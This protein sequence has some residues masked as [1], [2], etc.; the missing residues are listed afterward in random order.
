[1]GKVKWDKDSV[2]NLAKSCKTKKEF[3]KHSGAY[4]AA[5]N[6]GWLEE[7][8]SF[9]TPTT[10][11]IIDNLDYE[12]CKEEALKYKSRTEFKNNSSGTY[13]KARKLKILDTICSHMYRKI[14]PKGYW[15]YEK[16]KEEALKYTS[17]FEFQKK[18]SSAYSKSYEEKW[19]DE[20]CSHMKRLNNLKKRVIY[21]FE[22][23]LDKN[24]NRFVYVGLTYNP[25]TRNKDHLL[26]GPVFDHVQKGNINFKYK[27]LTDFISEEEAQQK[28]FQILENYRNTGWITLNKGK[29]GGLGASEKYTFETCKKLSQGLSKKEFTINENKAYK[30]CSRKG[31]LKLLFTDDVKKYSKEECEEYIKNNFIKT[32]NEL[33]KKHVKIY[34]IMYKNKWLDELLPNTLRHKFIYLNKELCKIESKKYKNKTEFKSYCTSVYNFSKINGWLDEF[35]PKP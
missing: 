34:T 28:E 12:K 8:Y 26:R 4:D 31:W 33:Q 2:I 9:L 21:S 6:K 24:N 32:R 30:T 15:S 13:N 7:I 29:T 25:E 16:C 17:K 1:M 10:K 23:D 14:K 27:I 19:L 11:K 5:I 3:K 22:F 20:I 18:C 35:F